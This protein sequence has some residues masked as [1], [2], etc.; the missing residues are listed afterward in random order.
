MELT[1]LLL[2]ASYGRG[3]G[4]T[5]PHTSFVGEERE[6]SSMD[7]ISDHVKGPIIW[8]AMADAFVAIMFKLI[9]T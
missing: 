4:I 7:S 1:F 9:L 5:G 8:D 3:P 2:R 6:S